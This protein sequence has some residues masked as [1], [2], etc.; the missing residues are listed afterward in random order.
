M[1]AGKLAIVSF[2]PNGKKLAEQIAVSLAQPLDGTA[3]DVTKTHKPEN[4]K[5]WC[6]RQFASQDGIL[7]IGAM[8]IAVR[9][10]APYVSS[11][12]FDPAVLVA[13]ELGQHVISVLSGHLGGGNELTGQMAALIGADPVITTASDVNHKI[14]IDVFAK[15]NNLYITDFNMAKKVAA[16]IVAGEKVS[17]SCEGK[18]TG[19]IPWELSGKREESA[20]HVWV[21][22]KRPDRKENCLWLIPKA[23]ILGIGCKKGKIKEQ[24]D[25]AITDFLFHHEIPLESIGEAVSIDLKKEEQ[26]LLEFCQSHELPICFYSAKELSQ[27]PGIYQ[28]SDFVKQ[29]TGVDNVCE[30]AVVCH[31]RKAQ[32]KANKEEILIIEKT[33]LEGVT[34]ALGK[35]EWGVTFG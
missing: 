4:L 23:Y 1:K 21:S 24:I 5:E 35:R 22:P 3:W 19:G 34:A 16:A 11:K 27:V 18:I 20:Y 31:V 6:G 30:R 13:D 32:P 15:K 10:I 33:K 14:A 17:F 2:T 12:V 25:N 26:G 8:G 29:I 28:E 9:T 7:F